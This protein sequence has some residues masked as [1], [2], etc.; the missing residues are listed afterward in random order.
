VAGA[1]QPVTL[2]LTSEH[3]HL[4][5]LLLLLSGSIL[6]T[7]MVVRHGRVRSLIQDG[8]A[9]A[10]AGL[11]YLFA[12][13]MSLIVGEIPPVLW[14]NRLWGASCLTALWLI[15]RIL[16]DRPV[17]REPVSI[18]LRV[19]RAASIPLLCAGIVIA[20]GMA[21]FVSDPGVR[22]A[23]RIVIDEYH[24]DWEKADLPMVKDVFGVKTVYNYGFLKEI[25]SKHFPSVETSETAID[26]GLLARTDVLVLKTPTKPYSAD[27]IAAIRQ[28]VDDGGGLFLIGDHTNIFGMNTYLNQVGSQ[29]GI[30]FHADAVS[31][32]PG[33][34]Q[35]IVS[36][37]GVPPVHEC[38][39][40]EHETLASARYLNH[41]IVGHRIPFLAVLTSCSVS[42]PWHSEPI[43]ISRGTF[44]DHPLFGGNTFFGNLKYDPDET[45]GCVLQNVAVRSGRGRIATWSDSTLFSNFSMCMTGVPELALGYAE[46][47]NRRNFILREWQWTVTLLLAAGLL[48]A[49]I[50][51]RHRFREP[52]AGMLAGL[53][54]LGCLVPAID[55]VNAAACPV[56][57]P[58]Q[59][60]RTLGFDQQYSVIDLPNRDHV[61][62]GDI[63][64]LESLYV[65]TQRL[66]L[67]PQAADRLS[68]LTRCDAL[69]MSN[70]R[71]DLVP[72][73]VTRLRN[74]LEQGGA[75]ILMAGRVSGN[76]PSLPARVQ[77]L[78]RLI[79]G[80]A[81]P[82]RFVA[83]P[84]PVLTD[85]H[86]S[87]LAPALLTD[88]EAVAGLKIHN[89]RTEVLLRAADGTPLVAR[90][91]LGHGTLILCSISELFS[92]ANLGEPGSV[93]N[94]RQELA[95]QAAIQLISEVLP[96]DQNQDEL[97]RPWDSIRRRFRTETTSTAP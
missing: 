25:L 34:Y 31:P 3:A 93:P 61:H 55:S 35:Q 6:R 62:R 26:A 71:R 76:A 51:G 66:H 86:G 82:D 32:L 44:V 17:P 29:W 83:M 80:L 94:P 18:H 39:N 64:S 67:F 52:A 10:L 79:E 91:P 37:P 23:G 96:W 73:D 50:A 27:E 24:S 47:L 41:P 84:R 20:L 53:L 48:G 4:L 97:K 78:N 74:F 68:D 89:P 22:K 65:L 57:P 56:N 63:K 16:L 36:V 2:V 95:L 54:L 70:P 60:F 59:G 88:A 58:S 85:F 7:V 28:F 42:G 40:R 21:Q 11:V 49:L 13:W 69:L 45:Y 72:E 14:S 77:S 19:P 46:W 15:I 33:Y 43:S 1:R 30:A 92:N 87:L 9:V 8:L 75:A 90:C 5:L 38:G 81:L 12:T